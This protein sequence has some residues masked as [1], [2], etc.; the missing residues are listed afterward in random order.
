[1]LKVE[2]DRR[3]LPTIN[4]TVIIATHTNTAGII[5]F[6]IIPF[7]MCVVFKITTLAQLG[8]FFLRY[9]YRLNGYI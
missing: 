2:T 8:L 1:M 3:L 7:R 6:L 4:K 9:D 5:N